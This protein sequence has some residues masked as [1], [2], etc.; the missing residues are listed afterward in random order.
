[1]FF[2]LNS[3]VSIVGILLAALSIMIV[4]MIW[5]H[6]KA[7]GNVWLRL[8]GKKKE[9]LKSNPTDMI[10]AAVGALV[11]AKILAIFIGYAIM[12][13]A[14]MGIFSA[15]GGDSSTMGTNIL[16]GIWSPVVTAI[17]TAVLAWLG[18]VI[19]SALNLVVWE[20]RDKKLFAFNMAHLLVAMV[21]A[22]IVY[23]L[24]SGG[25]NS[26]GFMPL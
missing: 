21:V 11:M 18:F 7:F 10:F 9:E 16:G 19:P 17:V 13:S 2:L 12:T 20:G 3:P 24:V 6:E 1:M 23:V 26:D 4:G 25:L 14:F 8:I 15:F 22:S 5:F